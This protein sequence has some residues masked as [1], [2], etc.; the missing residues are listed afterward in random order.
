[1]RSQIGVRPIL[2]RDRSSI[3]DVRRLSEHRIRRQQRSQQS[4]SRLCCI[5]NSQL[6][7]QSATRMPCCSRC[8]LHD[9]AAEPHSPAPTGSPPAPPAAA[10]RGLCDP[11]GFSS[12]AQKPV[13]V[14]ILSASATATETGSVGHGVGRAE[15]RVVVAGGQRPRPRAGRRRGRS[16]GPSGP[17][18]RGT[19]RPS[20]SAGRPWRGGRPRSARS[21]SAPTRGAIS[22]A[23]AAM[24]AMRSAW[25][26]SLLWKVHGLQPV[27]PFV[28]ARLG[29]RAGRSPRRTSRP[30]GGRTAPS[31]CPAGSSRRGRRSR[32]WRR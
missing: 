24:R 4:S 2:D 11:V 12:I 9:R 18:I 19:R 29:H 20:P 32:C 15:G 8:K 30:T 27:Q 25:E 31:G 13:S 22:R 21:G 6:A 26:P 17:A 3:A 5:A 7:D 16:S 23:S 14:S 1:M 28:H 10:R